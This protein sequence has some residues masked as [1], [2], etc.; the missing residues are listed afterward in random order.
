MFLTINVFEV[1]ETTMAQFNLRIKFSFKDSI[2][3]IILHFSTN[4]DYLF[5]VKFQIKGYGIS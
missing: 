2:V 1:N 5:V 4:R 3:N